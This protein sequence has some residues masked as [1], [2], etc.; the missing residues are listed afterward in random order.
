M[1][2][3]L[4]TV[5]FETASLAVFDSYGGPPTFPSGVAR[6]GTYCARVAPSG[7]APSF[8]IFPP[9]SI[10]GVA[11]A[12][13][14]K[15]VVRCYLRINAFP[16]AGAPQEAYA[17][18]LAVA[19]PEG[20]QAVLW[21]SGDT[22]SRGGTV[23]ERRFGL[24]VNT[25]QAFGPPPSGAG[26]AIGGVGSL[27]YDGLTWSVGTLTTGIWYEVILSLSYTSGGTITA[28]VSVNGATLSPVGYTPASLGTPFAIG[29][30]A[31]GNNGSDWDAAVSVDFDD[32]QY[33][34]ANGADAALPLPP[35]ITITP[36]T[37]TDGVPEVAYSEL[38][39]AAGGFGGPYT[40]SVVSGALPDGLTLGA[41]GLL[42]GTPTRSGAFTF[43][44]RAADGGYTGD[45]A[46][47]LII[48]GLAIRIDGT[49]RTAHVRTSETR[50]TVKLSL[51]LGSQWQ[52]TLPVFDVEAAT[53]YR[54]AMDDSLE[55]WHDV[56]G[57][58]FN[59]QITAIQE[60]PLDLESDQGV[61]SVVTA[62]AATPILEQIEDVIVT[63]PAGETRKQILTD[64][65]DDYLADFGI[66]LDPGITVGDT[67]P[68]L[69]FDGVT[70]AAVLNKLAE[71]TGEVWR[72]TPDLVLEMFL[73][74]AKIAPF[75]LGE[76][77]A[78]S[79][80]VDSTRSRFVNRVLLRA[81]PL[82]QLVKDDVIVAD[83]VADAWVMRY[84]PISDGAGFIISRGVVH[85]DDGVTPFDATLSEPGGGGTYEFDPV[86]NTLTRTTGVPAAGTVIT[87]T[88]TV[89]FPISV[90][91]EDAPSIAA[92]GLWS[93]RFTDTTVTDIDTAEATAAGLLA[94]GLVQPR[95]VKLMTIEGFV[96]PGTTID[97]AFPKRLITGEHVVTNT[98]VADFEAPLIEYT[99]TLQSGGRAQGK[100]SDTVRSKLDGGT[101]GGGSAAGLTPAVPRSTVTEAD[102]TLSD[103]TTANVSTAAHGF[104]PKAPGDAGKFL[105]GANPPAWTVPSGSG[106]ALTQIAQIVTSGSQATV[107][108]TAIPGTYTSLEVRWSSR[109]TQGG[110]ASVVARLRINNDATAA[111]YT[112]AAYTGIQNGAA[113]NATFAASTGGVFCFANVQD[114]NTAGMACQGFL[115]IEDYTNTTW[116]KRMLSRY[117]SDDGTT[118]LTN[119]ILSARWKSTAAITRLTF[120]TDG[121]AFKNGSVFTLYGRN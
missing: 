61:L 3:E 60:G 89:Q 109:D 85:E 22:T 68:E 112:A 104:A 24:S 18:V 26:G 40:F 108:F 121:T 114:G 38:L 92:H 12:G 66:T 78:G 69:V 9:G 91:V 62:R 59:G 39:G 94:T 19:G 83:G 96:L 7:G 84:T 28:S 15:V 119:L 65:V 56:P 58:L 52:A 50:R 117:A 21:L 4:V 35:A 80:T 118:N 76:A 16:T 90:T 75:S 46:F 47:T 98:E 102:L 27:N 87:F 111:N 97:L 116:H 33:Y 2:L 113:L 110:T 99:Y 120:T 53:G 30:V 63:F 17:R 34:A 70:P 103:N 36:G 86:T 95:V 32:V 106:G 43:T 44:I 74:G 8:G 25:T 57:T 49:D 48:T 42:S 73:I 67:L 45:Q 115:S 31:I 54:P 51:A 29:Q 1:A 82:A 14:K 6:R 72:L 93:K 64:L 13:A 100:F 101:T 23:L 105:N 71:L 107:D 41:D 79:V 20:G 81:G 37:L 77:N 55:I 5:G 10:V 11:A 88:S